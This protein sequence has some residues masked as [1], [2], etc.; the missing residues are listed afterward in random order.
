[1]IKV[2]KILAFLGNTGLDKSYQQSFKPNI[3]C[4]YCESNARIGLTIYEEDIGH[5]SRLHEYEPSEL[6]PEVPYGFRGLMQW[7]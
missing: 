3:S 6:W 7:W 2:S 4:I 1:M 5:I